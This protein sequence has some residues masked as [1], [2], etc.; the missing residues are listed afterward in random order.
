MD[1]AALA[2]GEKAAG[3][4]GQARPFQEAGGGRT[5][6]RAAPRLRPLDRQRRVPAP[7]EVDQ[8]VCRLDLTPWLDRIRAVAGKAGRPPW[9]PRVGIALWVWGYAQPSGGPAADRGVGRFP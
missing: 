1:V 6:A 4:G 8:F 2:G 7:A 3:E 5:G 9:D